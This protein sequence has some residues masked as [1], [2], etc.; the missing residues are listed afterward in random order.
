[1]S[2]D[3]LKV[4]KGSSRA[5]AP[6]GSGWPGGSGRPGVVGTGAIAKCTSSLVG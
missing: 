3:S 5:T 4:G 6:A 2:P 1:M